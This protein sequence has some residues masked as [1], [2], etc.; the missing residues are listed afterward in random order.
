M[1]R[2]IIRAPFAGRLGIYT[3]AVG[4]LME[5]GERLTTLTG[6]NQV[7]WIDFKVPQGVAMVREGDTVR[8]F[9]IDDQLVGEA[10]VL[11]VADALTSGIRAYDV[12]AEIVASTLRHGELVYVEVRSGRNRNALRVP[13][14]AVRWNSDGPHVFRIVDAEPEVFLKNRA[15]LRTVTVL[16]EKDG[17]VFVVGDIEDG[18]TI[19]DQGAFKLSDGSLV[20]IAEPAGTGQ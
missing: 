13:N 17:E 20:A 11:A 18:D 19:A 8:I 15:E 3:Q 7:R 5:K 9:D 6:L 10:T 1:S 16:S 4:D 12:R 14:N 2:L